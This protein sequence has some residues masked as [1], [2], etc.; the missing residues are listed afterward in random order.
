MKLNKFI[1][2]VILI[3]LL[4]I[5]A[6]SD[7]AVYFKTCLIGT[8]S[9][10][11]L[12]SIDG[13][14]LF[15]N[16]KSFVTFGPDDATYP[17]A[18]FG[19]LLD[20]DSAAAEDVAVDTVLKVVT[21]N[22]NPRDK[23]W[24]CK[25]LDDYGLEKETHASEHS[26]GGTDAI[27]ATNLASGCTDTQVLGGNGAGTGVECQ[28][29][30]DTPDDDSEVPDDITIN[31]TKN[32][33]TTGDVIVGD[34]IFMSA[35]NFLKYGATLRA[36]QGD[37]SSSFFFG[38]S[39]NTTNTGSRNSGL[40][41]NA[42]NSLTNGVNNVAVGYDAGTAIT[43]GD[44]NVA[45]GEGAL[46]TATNPV[47]VIAIG[48][49][50]VGGADTSSVGII[51]IGNFALNANTTGVQNIAIGSSALKANTVGQSNT[52][53]GYDSME[54]NVEGSF[55]T[56]IGD[57]TLQDNCTAAALCTGDEGSFNVAV[58]RQS[59]AQ[60]TTGQ[61]NTGVGQAS[62][63]VNTTGD[64]N[65]AIGE[66]TLYANTTGSFNTA[67]GRNSMKGSI[68]GDT[69]TAVGMG[70]LRLL[71]T[72]GGNVALGYAAGWYET[73]SNAFYVDNQ[74]RTNEATA[75]TSSLMYGTF[76]STV[77]SQTLAINAKLILPY[78]PTGT[79]AAGI[80]GIGNATGYQVCMTD[81]G[82]VYLDTNGG[83]D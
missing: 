27:T 68:G 82:D 29:D 36:F 20:A 77:A 37:G 31:S 79:T 61:K 33:E 47:S 6:V 13:Q 81:T 63:Y 72:G 66:D 71:T 83:C 21:P 30:D 48:Q 2:T 28:F 59:M 15:N 9:D 75:K 17:N 78:I 3:L 12:N 10:N 58:G 7:A 14:K 11:C 44:K 50:A 41:V 4:F 5:P 34:D 23:R 52:A 26:L 53:F 25:R 62:L 57:H 38:G 43:T 51:G 70:S 67:L 45:I 42:I 56:A 24:L 64:D 39:G 76:N 69:N 74:D 32:I 19:C 16:Y 18:R 60:N 73:G 49:D 80:G 65:T 1:F 22:K 54:F 46:A 35:G 55:N 40:G 8:S